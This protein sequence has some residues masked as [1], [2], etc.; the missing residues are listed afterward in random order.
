MWIAFHKNFQYI[1]DTLKSF[2]DPSSLKLFT[3][4]NDEKP[5]DLNAF[6]FYLRFI[7]YWRS[8]NAIVK[9]EESEYINRGSET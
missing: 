2:F 3:S 9:N 5:R 6:K 4:F 8:A 7:L 1:I